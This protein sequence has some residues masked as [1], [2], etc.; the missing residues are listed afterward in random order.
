[1]IIFVCSIFKKVIWRWGSS[2]I[3]KKYSEK[4]QNLRIC[5]SFSKNLGKTPFKKQTLLF[6]PQSQ[7]KFSLH[8]LDWAAPLI[9]DSCWLHFLSRPVNMSH[10]KPFC[11]PSVLQTWHF[12]LQHNSW[13]DNSYKI[14]F[15]FYFKPIL[16]CLVKDL[17]SLLWKCI[18]QKEKHS[19][20][21]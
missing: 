6:P 1:M 9:Q 18:S 4:A 3:A 8:Q 11:N 14:Y 19:L 5:L 17:S 15:Y 21:I 16:S 10:I 13:V 20:I 2:F 12:T 7:G